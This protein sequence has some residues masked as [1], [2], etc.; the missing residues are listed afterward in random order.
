MRNLIIASLIADLPHEC[1]WGS[2]LA[3]SAD[4]PKTADGYLDY[5]NFPVELLQS[6]PDMTLLRLYDSNACLRY[7]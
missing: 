4:V 3:D 2:V 7:R 5:E 6:L 1:E